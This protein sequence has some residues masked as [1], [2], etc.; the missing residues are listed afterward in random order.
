MT[1]GVRDVVEDSV[2]EGEVVPQLVTLNEVVR[3]T[4]GQVVMVEVAV[5]KEAV[6]EV[7]TV[8][9]GVTEDRKSVV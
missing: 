7:V 9:V 4:L 3:V 2:V 1:L 6:T 8:S 5:I